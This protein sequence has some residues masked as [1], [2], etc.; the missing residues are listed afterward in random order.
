MYYSYEQTIIAS[1]LHSVLVLYLD[2]EF[3]SEDNSL[4]WTGF[5]TF[6]ECF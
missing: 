5:T 2:F 6:G 3:Y 1:Q 4:F